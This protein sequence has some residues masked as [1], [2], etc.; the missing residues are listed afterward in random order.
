M[1]SPTPPSVHWLSKMQLHCPLVQGFSQVA[2]KPSDWSQA[3]P[4][5]QS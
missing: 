5:L 2:T 4:L 1:P 3:V